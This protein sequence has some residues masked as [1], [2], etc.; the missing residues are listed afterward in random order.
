MA[1]RVQRFSSVWADQAKSSPLLLFPCTSTPCQLNGNHR[2]CLQPLKGW[3]YRMSWQERQMNEQLEMWCWNTFVP[4]FCCLV[5]SS[6]PEGK[7]QGWQAKLCWRL[8]Q[9][10]AAL[11]GPRG[12]P[13]QLDRWTKSLILLKSPWFGW[14]AHHCRSALSYEPIKLS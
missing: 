10:P 8:P 3:W 4:N 1:I 6:T 11:G 13:T 2:L 14:V 12:Q 5:Y 9:S 7:C